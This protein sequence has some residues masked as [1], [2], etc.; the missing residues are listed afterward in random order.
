MSKVNQDVSANKDVMKR[1]VSLPRAIGTMGGMVIGS[2]IFY[3]C[4]YVLTYANGNTGMSILAW[5]LAGLLTM[6][7]GL[8]MAELATIMPESGGQYIYLTRVYGKCVGFTYGWADVLINTT[9]GTAAVALVGATYIGTL[10][11]GFSALQISIV[12]AAIILILGVLNLVGA[13]ISSTFSSVLF[14][15]K[16]AAILF[17]VFACYA[18][19][20]NTGTP[21]TFSFLPP[22]DNPLGCLAFSMVACLWCFSGWTT[23][24]NIAGEIENPKKNIP[25][26]LLIGLSGI[27]VVYVLFNLAVLRILPVEAIMQSDNAT[28]DVMEAL[29]GKGAAVV[30]TVIIISSVIGTTNSCVMSY[31]REFFAM[32]RDYRWFASF[33]RLNKKTG[34]PVVSMVFFIVYTMITCFISDFGT[35]V[36]LCVLISWVYYA[37]NVAAVIIMRKRCP[38]IERPYKVP[39][40]PVLPLLVIFGAIVMLVCNFIWSPT[41]VLGILIPLSGVPVYFLFKRYYEKHGYPTFDDDIAE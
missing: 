7:A 33:G 41:A 32:A 18:F 20:G 9:G 15:L 26:S 1:V 14:V 39:F 22:T 3:T 4:A 12:G 37:M 38:D 30:V 27:I 34:I 11:G 21:V 36:D 8:C 24:C 29:F 31:P 16:V 35:L 40:Y 25:R 19:G 10:M 6:G 2:A 17:V 13:K 5:I 23:I 28:Y